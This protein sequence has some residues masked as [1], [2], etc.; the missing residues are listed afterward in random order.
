MGGRVGLIGLGTLGLAL[1][2]RIDAV[3]G[4]VVGIDPSAPRRAAC[5]SM[6]GAA[7][8]EEVDA[9][10][11][12][13]RWVVAVRTADQVRAVLA[14]LPNDMP[15]HVYTT[16]S[17]REAADACTVRPRTW[18]IAVTGGETAALRGRLVAAVPDDLPP[19]EVNFLTAAIANRVVRLGD[20][21]QVAVAK[22]L[23]NAMIAYQFA[24]LGP[25]LAAG[26]ELGL[27]ADALFDLMSEGSAGSTALQALF[28][29]DADLLTPHGSRLGDWLPAVGPDDGAAGLAA[30]RGLVAEGPIADRGL[31]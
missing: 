2:R 7:V 24:A 3:V 29:Y 8:L 17:P 25:L 10:L 19:E 9:D 5:S 31:D 4:S 23:V 28:E 14:A 21:E 1:A 11:S 20:A 6:T 12:C 27:R 26:S 13:D 18:T 30:A 16:L 15:C 22:T